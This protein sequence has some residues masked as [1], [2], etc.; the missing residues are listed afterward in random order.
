MLS[1]KMGMEKECTV[2]LGNLGQFLADRPDFEHHYPIQI[3]MID[4]LCSVGTAL[5]KYCLL[6]FKIG[7]FYAKIQISDLTLHI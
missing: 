7:R 2:N 5:Q 3:Q 6:S 4:I 1:V